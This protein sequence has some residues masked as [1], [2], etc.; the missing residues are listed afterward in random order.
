MP[1]YEAY[2]YLTPN[3]KFML[4]SCSTTKDSLLFSLREVREVE[5][6]KFAAPEKRRDAE[7]GE[8][9]GVTFS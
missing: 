3:E 7:E 4:L 9:P 5:R 6:P 2:G 1:L 8:K